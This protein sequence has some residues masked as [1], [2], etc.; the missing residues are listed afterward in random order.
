MSRPDSQTKLNNHTP[1]HLEVNTI[2]QIPPSNTRTQTQSAGR[3][4]SLQ[5][6]QYLHDLRSHKDILSMP[7]RDRIKHMALHFFKYSAKI[8]IS[9]ER[10]DEQ[11][12]KSTLIDTLIICLATCNSLNLNIETSELGVDLD[13]GLASSAH[14]EGRTGFNRKIAEKALASLV[15]LGGRMAKSIESTD[16]MEAGNPR[17]ELEELAIKLFYTTLQNL[18]SLG[19][20][21]NMSIRFRYAQIEEATISLEPPACLSGA[22]KS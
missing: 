13:K 11:M 9:I 22:E 6:A 5:R 10:E 17:L 8:S 18:T 3:I 7:I 19:V 1:Q 20:D 16:H 4:L 15:R 14:S 21:V 12:L 2:P